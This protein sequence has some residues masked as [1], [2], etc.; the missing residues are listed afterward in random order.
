MGSTVAYHMN[1][2]F[3]ATRKP[4]GL[5]P[6]AKIKRASKANFRGDSYQLRLQ[7]AAIQKSDRILLVDDW[8]ETGSQ[9]LTAKEM[10]EELGA[11]YIGASIT[12]DQMS[13]KVRDKLKN[14]CS[15]ISANTLS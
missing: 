10:I 15:I 5:Y 13:Q 11:S 4:G 3:V 14:L 1:I 9:V 7:T 12:A 2:G 8:L 6:G